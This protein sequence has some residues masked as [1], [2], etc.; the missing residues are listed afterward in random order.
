MTESVEQFYDQQWSLQQLAQEA[1]TILL[2]FDSAISYSYS[3]LGNLQGKKLL[4]IGCG[5]GQQAL[6]FSSKGSLV[7]AIDISEEC[8]N[9]VR[10]LIKKHAV[11][12]IQV[13]N[14][15]AHSL[16]FPDNSFEI[17]YLNS[18]LMH[19]D[20]EK[21][22]REC[23]RVLAPGGSIIIIEPL[24][25]SPPMM[26]Y[27]LFSSYR[28]TNPDYMSIS[29]FKRFAPYFSTFQHQ[30]FYFFSLVSLPFFRFQN[31]THAVRL[32]KQLEKLDNL[33]IHIFPPLRHLYWVSVV[34]YHK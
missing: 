13:Q 27:R 8:L 7:T 30:E 2:M 29:Q 19:A 18:V 9:S 14:M 32:S 1:N 10:N 21:M 12:N 20:K 33:L 4:E 24:Q 26:V 28:K 23:H 11:K 34:Q 16:Q 17:I 3:L 5:S 22:L 6:Y 15:D 25:Y 31:T